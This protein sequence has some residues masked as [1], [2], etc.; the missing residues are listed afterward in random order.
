LSKD[1]KVTD[2]GD[3]TQTIR[4]LGTGNDVVYGSNGKAIFR[5]PGQFQFEILADNGGTP[6]DPFDDTF[7]EELGL[8]KNETGRSDDF[9]GT[10]VPAVT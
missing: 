7:L 10:V 8:V 9:C 2:N 3:G 1:L 6:T 5:S 4:M